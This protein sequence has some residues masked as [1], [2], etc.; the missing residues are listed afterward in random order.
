MT[1]SDV[2]SGL[3]E[4]ER[5]YILDKG[6]KTLIGLDQDGSGYGVM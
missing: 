3:Y 4:G 5:E 2:K 1:D 6:E